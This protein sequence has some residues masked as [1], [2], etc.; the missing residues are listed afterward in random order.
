MNSVLADVR[1]RPLRRDGAHTGAIALAAAIVVAFPL[2]GCGDDGEGESAGAT[3]TSPQASTSTS[4]TTT[5][6]NGGD[7]IVIER[8]GLEKQVRRAVEAVLT[9]GDPA[10]ACGRYVTRRYLKAAYGGRQGCVQAQGP[11][12]AASS[13]RSFSAQLGQAAGTARAVA[14]PVG[15]PY[16]GV[17]VEVSLIQGGPGYE[18]D[19]LRSDIPVGP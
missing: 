5:G 19:A 1:N 18:V 16:D 8:A 11:G 9:S 10:D 7:A 3:T 12:S 17:K 14:V 13:L 6:G 2:T 4:P 15:G